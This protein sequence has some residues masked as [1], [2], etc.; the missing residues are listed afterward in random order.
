MST[1]AIYSALVG[2]AFASARPHWFHWWYE[3]IL[4][5]EAKNKVLSF[6]VRPLGACPECTSGFLAL[7][8]SV[9]RFPVLTSEHVVNASAAILLSAVI[10]KVYEWSKK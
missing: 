7:V 5:A 1:V 8:W 3:L 9:Y 2:V 10:N 4:W 6:M